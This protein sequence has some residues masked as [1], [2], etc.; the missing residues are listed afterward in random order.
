MKIFMI[1]LLLLFIHASVQAQED[2]IPRPG[3]FDEGYLFIGPG[4]V[5][6]FKGYAQM[7]AYVPL[8]NSPGLSEFLIRR[9]RFAITGFFH[10]KF[11]YMLYARMD[12]GKAELN[13]AFLES[14]HLSFARFRVG[15]FKV[16]FSQSNLQSSSQLDFVNRAF[17]IENFSPT[18][19]IGVMMFGEDRQKIF[20]YAV[21]LF[22]GEGR[23]RAE[24]NSGKTFISR[25][26]ITPFAS[27]NNSVVEQLHIGGSFS[28]G[29]Q[30]NN[31]GNAS[32]K[33]PT[34][35]ELLSFTDSVRQSGKVSVYGYDIEW[36][37][38]NFGLRAEYMRYNAENLVRNGGAV[39]LSAD[40]YYIAA[41]YV[42][43]GENK[44]RNANIK[45]NKP[46]DAKKAGWGAL[47][48]AARYEKSH[49]PNAA[50]QS[51]LAK[52]ANGL[53]AAT[54]G[55]NWYVN[56]DVKV[57]LNYTRYVFNQPISY[58]GKLYQKSSLVQ[59]RMQYQF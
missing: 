7:D 42:L 49:L 3:D 17:S 18:Y 21:G 48:L 38:K 26:V 37:V 15:Q 22:N 31:L 32:Y 35:T 12:K 56:D 41:T 9:A 24:N 30:K 33:L 25:V 10:E 51:N 43:T 27:F 58:D 4:D 20:N 16:P 57:A 39:D 11:R 50:L 28:Q 34:E 29:R 53:H 55:L 47:E 2:S 52:G 23:N 14:R 36:L 40:G 19:D 13:E 45:P 54:A 46:L 6:K 44:K 5:L 1:S 59:L 8:R